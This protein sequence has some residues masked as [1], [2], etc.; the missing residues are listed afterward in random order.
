MEFHKVEWLVQ[1]PIWK[2][3]YKLANKNPKLKIYLQHTSLS[4]MDPV[5]VSDQ[6]ENDFTGDS[7]ALGVSTV[8]L[9]LY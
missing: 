1:T 9:Y 5:L 6:S 2:N 7:L 4:F 3:P 8:L